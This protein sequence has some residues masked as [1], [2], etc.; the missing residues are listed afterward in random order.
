[1][2][3][4]TVFAARGWLAGHPAA[5]RAAL[6]ALAV[7][8]HIAPGVYVYREG[9]ES[10]GLYGVVSG[11]IGIEGGHPRQTPRLGHVH[12]RGDWFGLRA[13]ID[14]GPRALSYRALEPSR[15]VFVPNSRLR[16]LMQG[17][18]AIAIR[19]G[20]LGEEGS[21]LASWI[22]RDLLTRDAGQRVAAVLLRVLGNGALAPDDPSGFWLTQQMLAEMSN[23][24]RNH[25]CRKLGDFAAAGWISWGYNRI[26]LLDAEG[27]AA[28]AY[29][30]EAA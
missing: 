16:P 2:D 3:A 26:R 17:D 28:F 19:V 6:L 29:G 9:S 23:L 1:M 30:D 24:S 22:V 7:P 12:R 25:V 18:A 8:V 11:G 4:A 13:P 14:G 27:L 5:F 21:R 10:H 20:Q 15:L